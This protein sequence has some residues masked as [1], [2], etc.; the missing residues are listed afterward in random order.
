[1]T[2]ANPSSSVFSTHGT[3]FG[4]SSPLEV[5]TARNIAALAGVTW[6]ANDQAL[7]RGGP[8]KPLTSGATLL[9]TVSVTKA[10]KGPGLFNMIYIYNDLLMAVQWIKGGFLVAAMIEATET[11]HIYDEPDKPAGGLQM[12]A[13]AKHDTDSVWEDE[14]A[15]EE[16]SE[17]EEDRV[18]AR[19]D[20]T[21][22]AKLFEKS[23][24]MAEAMREQWKH[25]DFKMPRGFR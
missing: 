1:M 8:V 3:L 19:K 25:D 17:D 5:K 10:E 18:K 4:Y 20:P 24:A 9:K 11:D 14:E 22:Q 21:K 2:H 6:R 23:Q 13:G 12:G 7:L 15:V 16:T